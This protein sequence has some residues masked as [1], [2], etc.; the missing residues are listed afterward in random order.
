VSKYAPE[1]APDLIIVGFFVNE[2]FDVAISDDEF[3]ESIGFGRPDPNTLYHVARM[4]HT[5][6]LVRRFIYDWLPAQLRR[7]PTRNGTHLANLG[8]FDRSRRSELEVNAEE[9][10]AHIASIAETAQRID[11]DLLVVLVPASIQVCEVEDLHYL[12]W[13]ADPTKSERYD[14]SQPQDL[15][16]DLLEQLGIRYMDLRP[17]LLDAPEC[18][19]HPRNMHW[20]ELGHRVVAAAVAEE[21]LENDWI[22]E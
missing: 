17:A 10:E 3:R 20:T 22:G 5:S 11:S 7:R 19:Y 15:A 13:R 2:F 21:L 9:V 1:Y 6:H 4:R 12:T 14:L 8:S 16:I 18:P